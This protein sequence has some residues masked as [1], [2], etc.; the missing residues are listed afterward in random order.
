ML[1]WLHPD[2]EV[3]GKKY[4]DI[5][6]RI[7][8]I[9]ICRGCQEAEDIADETFNRVA[10][11]VREIV[12]SY[13]GDPTPYFFAVANRV[14]QEYLRKKRTPV[15]QPVP[16]ESVDQEI[17]FECLEA[18]MQELPMESRELILQYYQEERQTKITER[19]QLAD[20]LGLAPNALR[21]RTYRIRTILYQCVQ[22]CLQQSG[23]AK[24]N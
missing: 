8:R 16:S 17:E 10:V 18:C 3:A 12:A 9:F 22:N 15:V 5:R 21:M 4:E 14:H 24:Q 1:A 19:K 13:D 11:K 2:R 7:I 20:K 23:Q 6:R